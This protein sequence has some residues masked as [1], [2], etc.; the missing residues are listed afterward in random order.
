M[1]EIVYMGDW[2]GAVVR[3]SAMT[4]KTIGGRSIRLSLST[5]LTKYFCSCRVRVALRFGQIVVQ[6][7]WIRQWARVIFAFESTLTGCHWRLYALKL[8]VA[9]KLIPRQL[10]VVRLTSTT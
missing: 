2:C 9:P 10:H 8:A 6:L 1:N 7:L 3:G 4:S 5:D